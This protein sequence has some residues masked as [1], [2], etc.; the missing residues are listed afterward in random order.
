V[1]EKASPQLENGFTRIANELFEALIAARL[2]GGEF[3]IVWAIIRKTYGF[4]QK[5]DRIPLSQ[6]E[7]LTGIPRKRCHKLLSQLVDKGVVLKGGQGKRVT[8]GV[9]KDY[10]QWRMSPKKGTK[11]GVPQKDDKVSPKKGTKVSPKKGNSKNNK[12]TKQETKGYQDRK[13]NNRSETVKGYSTQRRA[14][15]KP[16]PYRRYS[17]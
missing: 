16:Q 10:T 4:N 12:D 6:F 8:Y 5:I 9:Q 7:A 14:Q 2:S 15:R 11:S 13:G 1:N 3:K 17:D